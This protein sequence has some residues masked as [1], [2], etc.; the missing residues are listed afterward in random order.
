MRDI[1]VTANG[2]VV[3]ESG[4]DQVGTGLLV[5]SVSR[6]TD[7][8]PIDRPQICVSMS[9]A[10]GL[11]YGPAVE[12]ARQRAAELDRRGHEVWDDPVLPANWTDFDAR[13]LVPRNI[14]SENRRRLYR[15]L[16]EGLP[17]G[18]AV[19]ERDP[20]RRKNVQRRLQRLLAD[21]GWRCKDGAEKT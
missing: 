17:L 18:E 10:S 20:K 3:P 15:V 8:Q 11:P 12:A 9:L 2:R 5:R 4:T 19:N 6:Y 13:E 7:G 14:S 21:L 16:V 1:F